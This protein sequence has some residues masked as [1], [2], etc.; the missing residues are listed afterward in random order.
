MSQISESRSISIQV[1]H[2]QNAHGLLSSNIRRWFRSGGRV[3]Y[4]TCDDLTL[5][6]CMISIHINGIGQST[7][8]FHEACCHDKPAIL[9]Q[10]RFFQREIM[11][12]QMMIHVMRSIALLFR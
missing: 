5:H 3:Q 8:E 10:Q 9:F 1:Y 7:H 11:T 2:S 6:D 12:H 4:Q